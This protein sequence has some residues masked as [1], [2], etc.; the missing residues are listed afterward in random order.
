MRREF[1]KRVRL[2][3]WTRCNGR[4]EICGAR[5]HPGRHRYDHRTPD[6]FGGEPTLSNCQ[7]ICDSCDNEK[8][9]VNDIPAIAKN[10]RVRNKHLGIKRRKRTIS[11]RRFDGT[12]IPSKWK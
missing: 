4:C 1:T 12:P 3:A 6:T 2:D 8:T 5:L 9:Y 10:N 11:G 7:V